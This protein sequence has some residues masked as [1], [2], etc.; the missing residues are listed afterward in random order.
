MILPLFTF[1]CGLT[2]G[3]LGFLILYYFSVFFF[4]AYFTL[5]AKNR[6]VLQ[7]SLW[8]N[9]QISMCGYGESPY[10]DIGFSRQVLGLALGGPKIGDGLQNS[11]SIIS[12][13]SLRTLVF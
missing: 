8:D 6:F 10:V 5:K 9:I 11:N 3:V 2:V 4:L 7:D 1:R 13:C 12:L